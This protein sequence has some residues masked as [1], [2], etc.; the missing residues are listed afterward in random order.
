MVWG[1]QKLTQHALGALISSAKVV[2]IHMQN[3]A[4]GL[5]G[6]A[7][8]GKD[9]IHGKAA[10]CHA[11]PFWPTWEDQD[12]FPWVVSPLLVHTVC[13]LHSLSRHWGNMAGSLTGNTSVRSGYCHDALTPPLVG[14]AASFH[15]KR[16]F[17]I[18][19]MAKRALSFANSIIQLHLKSC[20]FG[21]G[22]IATLL[23]ET[24]IF[25]PVK[26]HVLNIS[27]RSH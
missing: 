3:Q 12:S 21:I 25:L 20:L 8:R 19:H 16:T 11:L 4:D 18:E 6:V 10:F 23:N 7:F 24:K 13:L 2:L 17:H 27:F 5:S 15:I 9:L 26:I 1:K 22:T 14:C